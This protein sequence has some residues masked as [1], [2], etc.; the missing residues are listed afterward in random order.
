MHYS[1]CWPTTNVF[2][3]S[4]LIMTLFP[5]YLKMIIFHIHTVTISAETPDDSELS[6]SQ[7]TDPYNATLLRTFVPGLYRT[8]TEQEN[9]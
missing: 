7:E 5:I 4:L 2:K 6:T 3:T 9:V 1:G 8:L